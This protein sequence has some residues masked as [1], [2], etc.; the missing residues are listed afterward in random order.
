MV[1]ASVF[2]EVNALLVKEAAQAF[3][4]QVPDQGIWC[5]MARAPFTDGSNCASSSLLSLRQPKETTIEI[6]PVRSRREGSAE[7][8]GNGSVNASVAVMSFEVESAAE[9]YTYCWKT[10]FFGP[11]ST[12]LNTTW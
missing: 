12:V 8:S 3:G 1:A 11:K 4:R 2:I 5:G 6:Q 10:V 9:P 7:E